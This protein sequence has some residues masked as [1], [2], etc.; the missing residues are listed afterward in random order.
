M[1]T[2]IIKLGA[3]GDVIRTTP[4]L[5]VLADEVHWLIHD[6]NAPLLAG[7]PAGEVIPWS[8]RRVLAGRRYD[9]IQTSG[10]AGW[11]NR[12]RRRRSVR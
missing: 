11:P 4:L 10:P 9:L 2:L 1:T 6:C 12:Y 8:K 7:A 5:H 3:A